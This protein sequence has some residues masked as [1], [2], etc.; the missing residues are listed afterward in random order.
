MNL[1]WGLGTSKRS[2]WLDNWQAIPVSLP[3]G[4]YRLWR[5]LSRCPGLSAPRFKLEVIR[6]KNGVNIFSSSLQSLLNVITIDIDYFLQVLTIYYVVHAN[7]RPS[8]VY[9]SVIIS[10]QS[11]WPVHRPNFVECFL[12]WHSQKTMQNQLNLS[13]LLFTKRGTSFSFSRSFPSFL[14]A[15]LL[16][17][18]TSF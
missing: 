14:D 9:A 7:D 3:T 18:E 13:T 17:I 4:P 16:I 6:K 5:I 2:Q 15:S 10:L 8:N 11:A 12:Q 1:G